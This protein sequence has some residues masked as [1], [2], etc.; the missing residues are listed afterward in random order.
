ME[1]RF[2]ITRGIY[3]ENKGSFRR[4]NMIGIIGAM[5]ME[6]DGIVGRMTETEEEI[7][8]SIKYTSGKLNGVPCVAA[9]CE[10][11]KVNAAAC[12]Q[13][14]CIRYSPRAVINSGV[15]GGIGHG[16]HIGDVVIG[17]SC[18]QHDFDTSAFGDEKGFVAGID[19]VY[20]PCDEN[21]TEIVYNEAK[22]IYEGNVVKGVIATG[23]Q[24]IADGDKCL[25]FNQR[26]NAQACEMEAASIAH[27]CLLNGI[28]FVGIRSI[29]DNANEHGD[30]DFT[31]FAEASSKKAIELVCSVINK[32]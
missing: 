9:R 3:K 5:D 28:P 30:V 24:F 32:L 8:A 19:R 4:R 10:P 2:I 27:V 18:V 23:D 25:E 22:E 7:I 20:L 21:M 13:A 26:Y 15:A 11:G 6:V 12:A 29:S 31:A 14:M 17:T 1:I 16:V